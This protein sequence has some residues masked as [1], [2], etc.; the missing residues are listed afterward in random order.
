M[1]SMGFPNQQPVLLPNFAPGI[2]LRISRQK[3]RLIRVLHAPGV[4]FTAHFRT[5]QDGV[6]TSERYANAYQVSCVA[7][8]VGEPFDYFLEV[9]YWADSGITSGSLKSERAKYPGMREEPDG[10]A[11]LTLEKIS[12]SNDI[13]LDKFNLIYIWRVERSLDP[14]GSLLAYKQEFSEYL[15]KYLTPGCVITLAGGHKYQIESFLSAEGAFG[16]IFK[17][18]MLELNKTVVLKFQ[19]A[20]SGVNEALALR[21]FYGHPGIVGFLQASEVVEYFNPAERIPSGNPLAGDIV[22]SQQ[23]GQQKLVRFY[24]VVAEFVQ[25]KNLVQFIGEYADSAAQ[26]YELFDN[27]P[28]WG[29]SGNE[30]IGLGD[31]VSYIEQLTDAVDFIHHKGYIHLDIKPQ[32]IMVNIENKLQIVDMGSVSKLGS[33]VFAFGQGNHAAPEVKEYLANMNR[34][35]PMWMQR[36]VTNIQSTWQAGANTPDSLINLFRTG[37]TEEQKKLLQQ[38][39]NESRLAYQKISTQSDIFSVGAIFLSLISKQNPRQVALPDDNAPTKVGRIIMYEETLPLRRKAFL[40]TIRK[41]MSVNVRER[42][43][44]CFGLKQAIQA[45][46]TKLTY[47]EI[48]VSGLLLLVTLASM[49]YFL[50]K[51]PLVLAGGIFGLGLVGSLGWRIYQSKREPILS[52]VQLRPYTIASARLF[53]STLLVGLLFLTIEFGI[54]LYV[55][56]AFFIPGIDQKS[57]H[58]VAPVYYQVAPVEAVTVDKLVLEAGYSD[59]KSGKIEAAKQQFQSFLRMHQNDFG[60]SSDQIEALDAQTVEQLAIFVSANPGVEAAPGAILVILFIEPD[61]LYTTTKTV[62]LYSSPDTQASPVLSVPP[63]STVVMIKHV[64]EN[65]YQVWVD[66]T[67]YFAQLE[68]IQ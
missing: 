10:T 19:E 65:W 67:L 7:Q 33:G 61:K 38:C 53:I 51:I 21:E 11:V 20:R 3:Y 64:Q 36:F 59:Y 45:E 15:E 60:L 35:A 2:E 6:V 30:L 27:I 54:F 42:Y 12:S 55:E 40:P 58:Q 29:K 32:N 62:D 17:A 16:T 41:A 14:K 48:L 43:Q 57:V 25:G 50:F 9:Y 23:Q 24:C 52:T 31:C 44:T 46:Y 47:N 34:T 22:F 68:G 4:A 49:L 13:K 66:K 28:E 8:K 37:M 18:K 63:S 26:F 39:E 5:T 1:T 56:R